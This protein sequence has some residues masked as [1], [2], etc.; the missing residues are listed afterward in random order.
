MRK[1]LNKVWYDT[2]K[3][4]TKL[5]GYWNNLPTSDFRYLSEDFY[6]TDDGK[7][8]YNYHGG[9]LTKHCIWV[10]QHTKSE[11]KGLAVLSREQCYCMLLMYQ[12]HLGE[13]EFV[14]LVDKYFSDLVEKIG[15][16]DAEQILGQL[17]N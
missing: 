3:N 1:L 11:S 2:E 8:F 7:F 9:A 13:S 6:R 10:D 15:D 14:N 5:F 16:E 12:N 4:S 17:F